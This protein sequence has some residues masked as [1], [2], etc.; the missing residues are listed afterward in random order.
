[1]CKSA[2]GSQVKTRM[3]LARTSPNSSLRQM[4]C[5]VTFS[6]QRLSSASGKLDCW[7]T[8]W[9]AKRLTWQPVHSG[10]LACCFTCWG[11]LSV[12]AL[13]F[14]VSLCVCVCVCTQTL[15]VPINT[16]MLYF[17][18]RYSVCFYKV[19][20]C[21]KHWAAK[22]MTS[23][24]KNAKYEPYDELFSV[25]VSKED[26]LDGWVPQQVRQNWNIIGEI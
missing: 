6:R 17:T 23:I 4:I 5:Q 19:V 11:S 15:L 14:I 16:L 26:K 12:C 13:L 7:Q 2:S 1:M 8:V 24:F 20:K 10:T 25:L 3:S 22:E 21:T 18:W 9:W